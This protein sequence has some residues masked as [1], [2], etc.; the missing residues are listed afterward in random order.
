MKT[1][2]LIAIAVSV[3]LYLLWGITPAAIVFGLS[4][5]TVIGWGIYLMFIKPRKN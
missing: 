4:V 3:A 2:T 5:A 1:F